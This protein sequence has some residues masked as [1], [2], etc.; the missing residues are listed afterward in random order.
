M[1]GR[2]AT[3]LVLAVASVACESDRKPDVAGPAPSRAIAPTLAA[4]T[5]PAGVSATP[6]PRA[7][8]AITIPAGEYVVGV[9]KHKDWHPK[10]GMPRKSLRLG[11]FELDVHEVTVADYRL[12]VAA[13][14]C[15]DEGLESEADCNW[16]KA[17]RESHP[18]NCVSVEQAA[19]YCRWE[20]KRLPSE[21]EWET[22]ARQDG[23]EGQGVYSWALE[24]ACFKCQREQAV[25]APAI[26]LEKGTCPVGSYDLAESKL[27]FKDLVGNVA[28]W[29]TGRLCTFDTKW[30]AEP[31][32]R[33]NAWCST[34]YEALP[35]RGRGSGPR[36][37]VGFRCARDAA[38]ATVER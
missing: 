5:P 32:A 6:T 10:E 31:V 20:N 17:G 22:A 27:G 29:T 28:E 25:A 7:R 21:E 33:G 1:N 12:C 3:A 34:M 13:A 18:I 30:C 2:R 38:H 16:S 24:R 37:L 23:L 14:V 4:S 9:R 35:E 19:T 36:A 26:P 11:A 8:P 15:N